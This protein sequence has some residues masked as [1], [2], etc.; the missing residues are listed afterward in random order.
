MNFGGGCG[1]F[2]K[3]GLNRVVPVPVPH[4]RQQSHK[5]GLNPAASTSFSPAQRGVHEAKNT[6]GVGQSP[7]HFAHVNVRVRFL[8]LPHYE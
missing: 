3:S 7:A 6:R 4:A 2:T 5:C 1:A 8:S